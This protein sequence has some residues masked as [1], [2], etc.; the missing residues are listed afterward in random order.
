MSTGTKVTVAFEL[1]VTAGD[2]GTPEAMYI[3][4]SRGKVAKTDEIQQD[5]LLADYDRQGR[6]VGIEVLAPVRLSD[7]A[8][9][10]DERKRTPFRRFV[11]KSAPHELVLS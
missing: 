6:L 2:D 5:V 10:V 8:K 7:L 4:L 9:L 1:S 11:R 3:C